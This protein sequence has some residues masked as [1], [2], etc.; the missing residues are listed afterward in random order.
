MA[1]I[2]KTDTPKALLQAIKDQIDEKEILTWS[3][4]NDGD[5]THTPDQWNKQAWLRPVVGQ[6]ELT[7]G[8]IGPQD[9][10]VTSVIYGVYHGRFIEMVLSHFDKKFTRVSATALLT[11]PDIS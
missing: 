4:D 6:G 11:E 3:Y 7:F 5:F 2:I 9:V 10:G 1:I 8:I